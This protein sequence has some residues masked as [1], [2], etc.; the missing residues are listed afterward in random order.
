MGLARDLGMEVLEYVRCVCLVA[1]GGGWYGRD[2]RDGRG[3]VG[4]ER[5]WEMSR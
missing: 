4:E 1:G 3:R 5:Y 2:G